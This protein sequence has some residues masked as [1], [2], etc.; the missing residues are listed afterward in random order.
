MLNKKLKH[1]EQII[2]KTI[3]LEKKP[4]KSNDNRNIFVLE[5]PN[6]KIR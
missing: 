3:K 5:K 1:C 4:L 2:R 6:T